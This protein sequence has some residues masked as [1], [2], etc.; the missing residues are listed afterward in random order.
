MS[1]PDLDLA[2]IPMLPSWTCWQSEMSSPHWCSSSRI[3]RDLTTWWLVVQI[4]TFTVPTES[5]RLGATQIG[6]QAA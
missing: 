2:V 5:L 1:R 3:G 6:P 4:G